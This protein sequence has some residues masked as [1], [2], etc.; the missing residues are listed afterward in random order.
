MSETQSTKVAIYKKPH[1]PGDKRHVEI[2]ETK[3]NRKHNLQSPTKKNKIVFLE[4]LPID[5]ID[6]SAVTQP[7]T[8]PVSDFVKKWL[9]I[10]NFITVALTYR[11][12]LGFFQ[13]EV[14]SSTN[15]GISEITTFKSLQ[16]A[17]KQY[18]QL[19]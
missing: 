12:H 1:P 2:L 4:A 11:N 14:N 18:E 15:G 6:L 5:K 3:F 13:L 7:E 19:T 10:G 17:M 16:Y 9:E 8:E